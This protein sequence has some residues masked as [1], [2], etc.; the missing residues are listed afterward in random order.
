MNG[1]TDLTPWGVSSV[2]WTRGHVASTVLPARGE[3][4][5]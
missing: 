4:I 5:D 2:L 1:D 3:R